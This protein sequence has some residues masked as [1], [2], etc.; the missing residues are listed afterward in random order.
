MVFSKEILLPA[1]TWVNLEDVILSERFHLYEVPKVI[2]FI[3]TESQM[4]VTRVWRGREGNGELL[5]NG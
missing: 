4:V 5:F 3:A 2:K 1:T